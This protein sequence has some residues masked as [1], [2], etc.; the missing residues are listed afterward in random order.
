MRILNGAARP[1]ITRTPKTIAS[2][3][4]LVGVQSV[5][6]L[7]EAHF[8]S[9]VTDIQHECDGMGGVVYRVAQA[10]NRYIAKIQV[11]TDVKGL[12]SEGF[13]LN[14]FRLRMGGLIPTPLVLDFSGRYTPYPVLVMDEL[15]G[16]SLAWS[17]ECDPPD[18]PVALVHS[19]AMALARLHN[20][21]GIDSASAGRIGPIPDESLLVAMSGVSRHSDTLF[22]KL[23][24]PQEF[25]S[26]HSHRDLRQLSDSGVCS[27]TVVRTWERCL[28]EIRIP[29]SPLV[30]LHGDPSLR[31]FLHDGRGVTGI[32]D[33]GAIVGWREVDLA[34]FMVFSFQMIAT[35]RERRRL[36][37]LADVLEAYESLTDCDIGDS[38]L[39]ETLI[40]R[41]IVS[42]LATTSRINP[43]S[44]SLP[45]L[46]DLAAQC[47]DHN[48]FDIASRR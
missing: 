22:E 45:V 11:F 4:E 5:R 47:V 6:Q 25:L 44:W 36:L 24:S 42:R 8:G 39:L 21:G 16:R 19:A 32:I 14:H 7:C 35:Q 34:A 9:N 40:L 23:V 10:A 1:T 27:A 13:F 12:L 41:K 31:N 43:A 3:S 38:F 2:R 26:H 48:A 17:L 28:S 18:E 29:S 30:Y 33:G 15:P 20:C 46:Q 37:A